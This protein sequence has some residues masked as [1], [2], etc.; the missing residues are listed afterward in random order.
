MGQPQPAT[1]RAAMPQRRGRA[2]GPQLTIS[3]KTRARYSVINSRRLK[4]SNCI[5]CPSQRGSIPHRQGSLHCTISPHHPS[6]R[7]VVL[8]PNCAWVMIHL[9]QSS[10][11][12]GRRYVVPIASIWS[13]RAQ[14]YYGRRRG[15]ST[16]HGGRGSQGHPG[17]ERP[18]RSNSW[19][20]PRTQRMERLRAAPTRVLSHYE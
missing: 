7:N 13:G 2:I 20:P 12:W 19:L 17:C 16:D 18:Q 15:C 1:L 5:R 14:R 10:G 8:F 11:P 6:H 4:C 9:L 3:K